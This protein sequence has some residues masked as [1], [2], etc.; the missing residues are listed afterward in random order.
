MPRKTIRRPLDGPDLTVALGRH[1]AVGRLAVDAYSAKAWRDG[2]ARPMA[3]TEIPLLI[4]GTAPVALAAWRTLRDHGI[5][6]G[7]DVPRGLDQRQAASGHW[8]LGVLAEVPRTACVSVGLS[9]QPGWRDAMRLI[10]ARGRAVRF[11]VGS[12]APGPRSV[13]AAIHGAVA[14]RCRFAWSSAAWPAVSG[15]GGS[16]LP[17]VLNVVS[18]TALALRGAD[19]GAVIRELT[20]TQLAAVLA[21]VGALDPDTAREVRTLLIGF[22]VPRPAAAVDALVELGALAAHTPRRLE[23][24]Q[25]NRAA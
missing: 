18:A 15:A 8:N 3:G 10:C 16:A 5:V 23:R 11:H 21:A 19:T 4:H 22:A 6:A 25:P 13:A 9:L 24:P 17:G 20:N 14:E 1:P 2:V 12:V 7:I